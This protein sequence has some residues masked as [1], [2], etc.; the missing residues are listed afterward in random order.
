MNN[1][2]AMSIHMAG[3][4]STL[5]SI[6]GEKRLRHKEPLA[7]HTVLKTDV[8]AEMYVESDTLDDFIRIIRS[9]RESKIPVYIL[10]GGSR[11][12]AHKDIPGLVIKNNCIRYDKI[13][14]KGH[15]GTNENREDEVLV[16]AESGLIVNQLVRYTI[17][18]GLEGLEY[19]LGLPGT[20]GGA[21]Y[22]NA[23]YI[24]KYLLLNQALQSISIINDVGELQSYSRDLP[25]FIYT[26]EYWEETKD[27][28]LSA[29][30]KLNPGDKKVLWAR[31][32][33]AVAWRDKEAKKRESIEVK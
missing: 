1:E 8:Y 5:E 29:V 21:I 4:I 30:F 3:V 22:T 17:E 24:P 16:F 9:A 14:A 10:G 33:E 20:V 32:E 26:D 28:I 12:E 15:K 19:Q 18:E 13:L 11:A 27:I 7:A 25:H 6:V 2:E 23:K 31:G